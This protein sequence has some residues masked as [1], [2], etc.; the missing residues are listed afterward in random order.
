MPAHA[1]G[2]PPK[3]LTVGNCGA[4]TSFTTIQSAVD[5]ARPGDTV[6]ICPGTYAE[7]SGQPGSSALTIGKSLTLAGAGAG[8]VTIK[9]RNSGGRIAA[10]NPDIRD[11]KGD[12][13]AVTGTSGSPVT[14][15]ISGVTV[16]AAGVYATAGVV[17]VDAGGSV[18]HSRITGLD[19]DESA[20]GYQVPGGFRS[21]PFGYGIAQVSAGQLPQGQVLTI[22]HTRIDHYNALGALVT[23]T[24]NR[25]VLTNDQIIGRDLCQN[26]NDPTA[27]GPAVIDGDCESTGGSSPIPPPLPLTTGPLFG[28]DGVRV[29]GGASVRMTGDTVS[30]NLVN[31]TGAP[32]QSVYA[33]TPD[34]DPYPLGDHAENNQNLRLAAGVRLA[35]A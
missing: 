11:G 6:N 4:G 33:P 23:G 29:T 31:G 35:G 24:G 5:A 9:P 21:N 2:S 32:V 1:A 12:I 19:T 34:N 16:D 8:Q 22:D 18:G 14:V 10:D 7:G 17:F 30:S 20:N 25:A 3:T 15:H 13:I 27:G 28:Q 26:Y